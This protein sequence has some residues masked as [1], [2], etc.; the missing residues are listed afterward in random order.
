MRDVDEAL[1]HIY[2]AFGSDSGVLFGIPADKM[3]SVR[4][5]IQAT[6][7]WVEEEGSY[8]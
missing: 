6:L 4:A 3:K 2:T 7:D 1:N 8:E 5:I